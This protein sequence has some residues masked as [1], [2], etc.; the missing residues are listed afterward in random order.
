MLD[1]EM[2]AMVQ[3]QAVVREQRHKIQNGKGDKILEQLG[4]GAVALTYPD[5]SLFQHTLNRERLD[6]GWNEH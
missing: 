2:G 3:Q 5:R 4:A 1:Q 6:Q